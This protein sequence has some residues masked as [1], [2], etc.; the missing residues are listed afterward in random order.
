MSIFVHFERNTNNCT[1]CTV[2][3]LTWMG[4][5]SEELSRKADWWMLKEPAYF[6]DGW[7]A[8]GNVRGVVG[9]TLTTCR[10]QRKSDELPTRANYN[11]RGHRS[12]V[13][14]VK[15]NEPFQ[16]LASCDSNGTIFVWIQ[17]EGRWAIELMNDRKTPV[18]DFSWSHHGQLAL[19]CYQDGF[20]LVGSVSGQ[21]YWSSMLHLDSLITCGIWTPDDQQV[22]LGTSSG[23]ILVI[24]VSGHIECEVTIKENV[25]ITSMAWSCHKFK[26]DTKDE[27]PTIHADDM[28]SLLAVCF[29]NG[30]IYLMKSFDDLSP[31]K[32]KTQ[33]N[34]I[35]MDW[36]HSGELLA[37]AGVSSE[38]N[39]VFSNW[40]YFYTETGTVQSSIQIPYYQEPVTAITWGHLDK[41]LFIATGC[42]VNIAWISYKLASLQLLSAMAVQ[43]CLI[44]EHSVELLPVVQCLQSLVS[45]LFGRTIKCHL[46]MEI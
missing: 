45:S 8:T 46:W 26:S 29:E 9:I 40:L 10:C 17:H 19:I 21:R 18:T 23:Q 43:K 37:I 24:D 38:I 22:L 4:R 44:N 39:G 28:K 12:H 34:G 6:E 11:L 20:V 41:R 36:S 27:F 5:I 7:L 42:F 13:T 35:K 1:D 16:K 32:I 14:I 31:V 15:W 30:S 3:S 2:L 33:L 25:A